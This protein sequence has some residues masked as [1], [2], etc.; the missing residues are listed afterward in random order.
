MSKYNDHAANATANLSK[1]TAEIAVG[2]F[3]WGRDCGMKFDHGDLMRQLRYT[4]DADAEELHDRLCRV[5]RIEEVEDGSLLSRKALENWK[6]QGKEGGCESDD[7]DGDVPMWELSKEQVATYYTLVVLLREK[8]TGRFL[9]IDPEGYEWPRYVLFP[10]S[11]GTMFAPFMAIAKAEAEAEK[12]REELELAEQALANARR[13]ADLLT[14]FAYL[15]C[16]RKACGGQPYGAAIGRN[17]RAALK[18][19]FPGVK[20]AVKSDYDHYSVR[21]ANG[22]SRDSVAAVTGL[23]WHKGSGA[24]FTREFG[25]S[26]VWLSRDVDQSIVDSALAH[27][28][29]HGATDAERLRRVCAILAKT[30]IPEGGN[31]VDF[32]WQGNDR[33]PVFAKA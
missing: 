28:E 12:A 13:D 2:D 32:E 7:V 5:T 16:N 18:R 26:D 22:P 33:V 30:D 29:L 19:E 11:Y 6:P 9:M 3:I 31:V 14:K 24:A 1:P 10:V 23:F 8:T 4:M 17:L 20:F 15:P 25:Y 27:Y 21:W